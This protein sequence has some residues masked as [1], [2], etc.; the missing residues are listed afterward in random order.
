MKGLVKR[1]EE[2]AFCAVAAILP[3][4]AAWLSVPPSPPPGGSA[5]SDY[6]TATRIYDDAVA[7]GDAGKAADWVTGNALIELRA[8]ISTDSQEALV[9]KTLRSPARFELLSGSDGA[10]FV[11]VRE[12]GVQHLDIAQAR[13]NA[14]IATRE[15]TYTRVV[16]LTRAG[17]HYQLSNLSETSAP[18]GWVDLWGGLLVRGLLLVAAV[19]LGLIAVVR[20]RVRRAVQQV[21]DREEVSLARSP[22]PA[23]EVLERRIRCFNGLAITDHGEDLTPTL[24]ARRVVAFIWVYL[25][26]LEIQRPGSRTTRAALADEVFPG[27]PSQTQR[28]RLRDRLR[29]IRAGLPESLAN[30]IIQGNDAV[31]FDPTGWAIDALELRDLAA[32]NSVVQVAAQP[33]TAADLEHRWP[34]TLLM[35]WEDLE[36]VT[37]GRGSSHEM[38]DQLRLDMERSLADALQAAVKHLLT[39]GDAPTAVRLAE[40]AIALRPD[41][42]DLRQ[43]LARAYAQAGRHGAA[44]DAQVP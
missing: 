26:A 11:Q 6:S 23:E 9:I 42:E 43:S 20:R 27:L 10:Q 21:S 31:G 40:R 33:G 32:A 18:A 1:R 30:C 36:R 5:S 13:G 16:S 2:V 29:D 28:E 22:V 14:V 7:A 15:R 44:A 25:L 17:G 3:L 35:E 39:I 41:R 19:A 4:G 34:G 24:L 12:A 37:E 38:I 8:Q